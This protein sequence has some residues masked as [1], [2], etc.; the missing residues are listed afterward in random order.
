MSVDI[1][2][3][4]NAWVEKMV[5]AHGLDYAM[6]AVAVMNGYE[7]L[8]PT[9]DQFVDDPHFLG[10]FVGECVA[11]DFNGLFPIWRRELRDIYPNPFYSPYDEVLMTG[12]IGLG[13]STVAKIG[14]ALDICRTQYMKDPHQQL[15]VLKT[16]KIAFALMNATKELSKGV[17]FDELNTWFN[18]SPYF[19]EL[20]SRAPKDSVF[21]K[22]V[23][24]ITGSRF[25]HVMGMHLAGAIL[26]EL[27]D[28]QAVLD[29]AYEN[30]NHVKRRIESRFLGAKEKYGCFPGRTWLD[31]SKRAETSFLEQMIV[32]AIADPAIKVCDFPVWEVH[33][34]KGIYEGKGTFKVFVGDKS[35]DP[36]VV[37]RAE[38]ITGLDEAM[39]LDIPMVYKKAFDSD[40]FRSLQDIAGKGTWSTFKFLPSAEKTRSAFARPNPVTQKI[41]QVEFNSQTQRLIDYLKHD[42][43]MQGNV[44]RYIHMDLGLKHDRTGICCSRIDGYSNISKFDVVSGG[45][46][47]VREPLYSIDWIM[48]IEPMAGSE[49]PIY[50]LK[51][52]IADLINYGYNITVISGDGYMSAAWH[53]DMNRAGYDAQVISVD[54]TRVPYDNLKNAILEGRLNGVNHPILIDE[55]GELLDLGKKIDHPKSNTKD[56]SDAVS[57][58]LFS[59]LSNHSRYGMASSIDEYVEVS[60]RTSTKMDMMTNLFKNRDKHATTNFG[61]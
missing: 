8:P 26:S 27:N 52:L 48:A 4:S 40:I 36:F 59:A 45:S 17:L 2:N 55:L 23:T 19:K 25:T 49:V 10:D 29:Q 53:Q 56:L 12:A 3:I 41:I 24:L 11:P 28:Q 33:G 54:K 39:V 51:E 18:I 5:E 47:Q 7:S 1:Q 50:K 42:K 22:N 9:L 20:T 37:E 43:I 60:K 16:G 30:Y 38:Q 34:F 57:G 13:K 35:R 6:N 14:L 46:A 58:S 15:G 61:S 32:S 44:P 31:S 21:P